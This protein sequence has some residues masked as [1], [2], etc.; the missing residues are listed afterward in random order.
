MYNYKE[1]IAKVISEKV[2]EMP[3]D[4][5]LSLVEY[6]KNSSMGD[7]AFPC[8]K[9][10]KAFR[11]APQAI[12]ETLKEQIE[13]EDVF[14]N[15]EAISGFLNFKINPSHFAK[16]IIGEVIKK[17]E[18]YGKSNIGVGKKTIIEYSSVNIAKPFHMGHIRSTMIGESLH[19]IYKFLGYDTV[20]INHLG[21]YGTQFGK[22][23]VAFKLWGDLETIEKD[24]IPE[25]LKIYVRFHDEAEANPDLEDEARLWFTRLENND[26]E[27]VALWTLFKDMSLK[28]FNRVYE[29]LGVTFDSYAG[30]SFYSDK[31]GKIL[32]EL[33]SKNIIQKSEGAEVVDLEPYGM[34]PALITKKDGSTL[35]M[36]RDLA[37]AKYRKETYDFYKNIYVVGTTQQ[38]HFRQWI[39]VIELM[40]Y[41]WAKD[42]VHVEFGTVSLEEGSLST[43]KG[44]VVFLEDVLDQAVAQTL[45]IINEKNPELKNKDLVANDVGIGAVV[46]QEL[47]TSRNKDYAFSL[48]KTLSFEGETG[49]YVQYTHAR[50]CSVLRKANDLSLSDIDYK[51]LTDE[52]SQTV[53]RLLSKFNEVVVLAHRNYEPHSVARYA[54]ELAQAF[55]RFYHDNAILVDDDHVKNARLA[56]VYST[57]QVLK[58]ALNLV[59][60]KAPEQM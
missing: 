52:A 45:K 14:L 11:K 6:P 60:V 55:N 46:F 2:T 18:D 12:A 35:Y 17:G 54:V 32:D 36:T 57:K 50:A 28:V 29:K 23:I 59:C 21:D 31:M 20:A 15:I 58:T 40:G 19:R 16:S 56:L 9:L 8:F 42:C 47:Y 33:R 10:A 49:P 3:F 41:N 25:L 51:H 53:I 4:E 30:E 13:L 7:F 39:K 37:A 24:P 26:E 1:L 44:K 5:I 27:A 34:P 22:L 48:S 43:R 38:L